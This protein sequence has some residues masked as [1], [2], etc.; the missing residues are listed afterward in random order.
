MMVRHFL[1]ISRRLAALGMVILVLTGSSLS[2]AQTQAPAEN[3]FN[4]AY[5]DRFGH[6][7]AKTITSPLH[8]D[9]EDWARATLIAGATFL[10]V[11]CDGTVRDWVQSQRTHNSNEVSLFF[12]RFGDGFYLVGF[13]ALLYAAGEIGHSDALR[14]TA[15]LSIESLVVSTSIAWTTK[16]V[17]G[18]ARPFTGEPPLTFSLFSLKGGNNSF[19]SGHTTAAFAVA[20][21]IA[22][23]TRGVAVD[24]LAYSLATLVGLSRIH[25]NEH[26]ASSVLVGWAI[27]H[28]VAKKIWDMNKP[29]SKSKV[30]V[31]FQLGRDR[32]GLTL[33][34]SF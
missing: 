28:F 24:I 18:R 22:E 5:L 6:D 3:R 7:F 2:L 26:W 20:T 9:K 21:I 8:W 34:I 29:G 11:A 16:F 32:R 13:S 14:K 10:L 4:K 15:L 19:P 17:V 31:G 25:D 30:S 12:R 27:G 33:A 1:G 23:Q